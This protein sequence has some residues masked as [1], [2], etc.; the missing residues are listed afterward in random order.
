MYIPEMPTME[1]YESKDRYYINQIKANGNTLHF[2]DILADLRQYRRKIKQW[3]YRSF[4]LWK[5]NYNLNSEFINL[6]FKTI[7]VCVNERYF[8]KSL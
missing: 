3:V 2:G 7:V 6:G 1:V 5:Y 8:D 4:S